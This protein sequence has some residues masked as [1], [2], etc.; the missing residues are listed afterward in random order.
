MYVRFYLSFT[1]IVMKDVVFIVKRD[2]RLLEAW[3][4][5]II[6]TENYGNER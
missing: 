2:E 6:Y 5:K 3:N 4:Y 1:T